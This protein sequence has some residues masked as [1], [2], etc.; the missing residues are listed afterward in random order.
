MDIEQAL[1]SRSEGKCELCNSTTD[2]A[3]YEVTGAQDMGAVEQSALVCAT[4]QQQ[5]DGSVDLDENHWRCLNDSMWS[6]VAAV[7]V[8][9]YRQLHALSNTDWAPDLLDM[10]YLEDNMLAW[11]QQGLVDAD[12]NDVVCKDSN[13]AT[14]SAGDTVT[15][16]KDL[17]VKGANFTAKRGTTVKNI[18]LTDNPEHIEGKVNGTR[19]V[20][21]SQF[22][23]KA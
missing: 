4:C 22:L 9:A 3:A 8:L 21:L 6:P 2:L 16:I 20:L 19:I 11:A 12:D 7:Q 13:G 10:L 15:L 17:V 5:L 1:I 23:K 14:L 18:S